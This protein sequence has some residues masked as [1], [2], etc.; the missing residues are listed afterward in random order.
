M[1]LI[2]LGDFRNSGKGRAPRVRSRSLTIRTSS[3]QYQPMPFEP[4]LNTLL[5][6][7]PGDEAVVQ[8][9]ELV[10]AA[11]LF[12]VKH[13]VLCPT[14]RRSLIEEVARPPARLLFG[15]GDLAAEAQRQ[16][17]RARILVKEGRQLQD[18]IDVNLR[19]AEAKQ[20]E[21]EA[22]RRRLASDPPASDPA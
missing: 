17:E 18:L 9:A 8:W 13:E 11:D 21:L 1:A 4:W 22:R 2:T 12:P 16:R 14:C 20:A 15:A 7:R 6:R 19:E 5:F 3:P 10:L